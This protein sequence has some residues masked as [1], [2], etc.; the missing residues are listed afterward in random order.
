MRGD[1]FTIGDRVGARSGH[2]K[3]LHGYVTRTAPGALGQIVW[4]CFNGWHEVCF[5]PD[6]LRH[7]PVKP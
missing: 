5:M 1:V 2:W 4:V 6:D 3:G 7:A